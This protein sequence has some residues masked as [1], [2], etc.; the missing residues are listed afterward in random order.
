M[1]RTAASQNTL[2]SMIEY[3]LIEAAMNCEPTFEAIKARFDEINDWLDQQTFEC[4]RFNEGSISFVAFSRPADAILF[5]LT[6]L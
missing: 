1:V 3:A 6:W 2:P 5:K 4:E